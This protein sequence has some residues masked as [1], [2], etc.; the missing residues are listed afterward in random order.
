[1]SQPITRFNILCLSAALVATALT[2]ACKP[3]STAETTPPPV[4]VKVVTVTARDTPVSFEYTGQTESSQTVEIRARVDGYLKKR[5]YQEGSLVD[6]GAPLF[7]IDPSQ[8]TARVQGASAKLQQAEGKLLNAQQTV[9][10][11]RPLVTVEAVSQKDM[12]AA[13]AAE[14]DAM[15]EVASARADLSTA[16]LNLGYPNLESPIRGQAGKASMAEGSF[17]SAGQ[18][19]LLTTVSALDPIFVNFNMSENEWLSY[20]EDMKKGTLRMPDQGAFDVQ[21]ILSNGRELPNRGKLNFSSELVDPQ[22]GLYDIRASFSNRDLELSPGQYVRVRLLGASRPNALLV[23]QRAV[24]QGQKGKFV[25]VV[26]AGD[27]AEM[28]PLEVGV[29]VGN[30]WLVTAGLRSGERVVTDGML[31]VQPGAVLKVAADLSENTPAAVAKPAAS[32]P[33]Q[34][35]AKRTP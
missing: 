18:S 30:H 20:S 16:E 32:V 15:G 28:R 17:V 24:M 7:Q 13:I 26:G 10:R 3:T 11:L 19:S 25:Y 27:K 31:K 5:S 9:Q 35:A 12:D 6:K 14:K 23:P 2:A 4:D 8:F 22:T 21:L 1:M 34:P 33:S 29:W